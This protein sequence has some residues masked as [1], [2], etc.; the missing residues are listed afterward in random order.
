[1][2]LPSHN[3]SLKS[4]LE[5]VSVNTQFYRITCYSL[6]TGCFPDLIVESSVIGDE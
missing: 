1:M 3:V 5:G 4:Q 2:V 6:T